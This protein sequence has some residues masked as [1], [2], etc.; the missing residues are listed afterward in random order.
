MMHRLFF[1]QIDM[2]HY[3]SFFLFGM[4]CLL[5]A[6]YFTLFNFLLVP[7]VFNVFLEL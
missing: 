6:L 1:I 4:F 3:E 5:M 7:F 2:M